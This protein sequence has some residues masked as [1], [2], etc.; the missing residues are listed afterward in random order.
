MT[1]KSHITAAERD[2]IGVWLAAGLS[3]SDIA[4]KLGR[5]KSSVS[6]EV[7]RNSKDGQYRPILANLLSRERNRVSRKTNALK[8]PRVYLH[9]IEKLRCNWSPEQ[10]AGRW[11]RRNHDQTVICPETIYRYIYS[12]EGRRQNLREYLARAHRK[13]YPRRYRKSY[14]R[15]IPNRVNISLRSKMADAREQFD[16]WEADVVEGRSHKAGIQTLLERKTRYY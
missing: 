16:H 2:Q 3:L 12:L 14:R 6:Y 13:R 4:W 10:I 8:D 5:S 11:R 9:V 7:I 1:R 15:G